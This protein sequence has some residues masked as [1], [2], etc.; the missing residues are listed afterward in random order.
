MVET[1]LTFDKKTDVNSFELPF[2]LTGRLL[3]AYALSSKKIFWKKRK[4]WGRLLQHL[5]RLGVPYSDVNLKTG[6]AHAP[7]RA[8]ALASNY[9]SNGV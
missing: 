4:I 2:V 8:I 9:Y 6:K 3:S 1:Q 5:K 7:M